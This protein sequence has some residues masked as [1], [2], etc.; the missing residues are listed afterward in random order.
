MKR[1]AALLVLGA[2]GGCAERPES[3]S[4]ATGP[5]LT[6]VVAWARAQAD[7]TRP[8]AAY[9]SFTNSGTQE[10]EVAA[11]SCAVSV[12]AHLHRSDEQGGLMVMRAAGRVTVAPGARLAMEPGALHVMLMDLTEPVAEGSRFSC[13]LEF[14]G[15]GTFAVEVEAR[16]S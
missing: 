6:R 8:G 1:S 14:S 12:M 11:I 2:L 4:A 16:A 3:S 10:L 7:T 13:L 5:R 9:I 15:G